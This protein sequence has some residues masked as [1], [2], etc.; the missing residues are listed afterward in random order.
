MAFFPV[1]PLPLSALQSLDLG[2]TLIHYDLYLVIPAAT[3]F[4]NKVTS[5][6]SGWTG[7]AERRYEHSS[8]E[9]GLKVSVGSKWL[10]GMRRQ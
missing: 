6:G 3:R 1:G 2:S 9:C 4:P 7:S 10:E 5:W 8:S